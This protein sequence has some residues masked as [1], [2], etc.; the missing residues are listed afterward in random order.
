PDQLVQGGVEPGA[1]RAGARA[2][3]EDL[4]GI[5]EVLTRPLLDHARILVAAVL[6]VRR[7]VPRRVAEVYV[8]AAV[9]D[10][11]HLPVV[12]RVARVVLIAEPGGDPLRVVARADA[13]VARGEG[14]GE[15]VPAGAAALVVDEQL[16]H[17]A[18]LGEERV[19]RAV[20][21]HR[22]EAPAEILRGDRGR[23]G[24]ERGGRDV[25]R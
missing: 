4:I 13:G 11:H 22:R 7:V 17:G 3:D 23:D 15:R 18:A 2:G 12:E 16:V 14:A 6:D 1:V 19:R 25:G 9:G 21:A 10:E 8:A 5:D 24:G 20:H